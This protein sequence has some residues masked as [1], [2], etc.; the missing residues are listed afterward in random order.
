MMYYLIRQPSTPQGTFGTIYK[1]DK[2]VLCRTVERPWEDNQHL[3]SCIPE[4]VYTCKSYKSPTK[5][6]VWMVQN[7]PNRSD[8]EIHAANV[9]TDLEGCIGVGDSFG[10][11][12]NT[13][14]VLNSQATLAMLRE[15][16]PPMFLLTISSDCEILNPLTTI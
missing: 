13:A 2:S 8:I 5:G 16:L 15:T 10:V 14:A 11:I 3:I 6:D 4:G 7:V 9:Y 1:A 12:G